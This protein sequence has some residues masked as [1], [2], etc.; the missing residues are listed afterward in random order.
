MS[1]AKKKRSNATATK[2][3]GSKKP[4]F[5]LFI[6]IVAFGAILILALQTLPKRRVATDTQTKKLH[7]NFN[8]FSTNPMSAVQASSTET[9]K[10]KSDATDVDEAVACLNRGTELL[11][12]GKIEAAIIEY[13]KAVKFNPEDE[14]THYNLAFA[15]AKQGNKAA[16]KQQYLE[17]LRI[18][19]DYAEAHNNLGN[20]LVNEGNFDEAIEHF[21]GA[22]RISPDNASANNNLGNALA[23]QGKVNEAVTYFNQALQ[24]K[25]DYLEARYNLGNAYLAQRRIDEA[26]NVFSEILRRKPDFEPA[27]RSLAKARQL[28]T[29]AGGN[30]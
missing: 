21:K 14:D 8:T 5:G 23:R 9:E 26:V 3:S 25:P 27:R 16:A 28:Q 7:T 19:P 11:A 29:T 12:R 6:V 15:L 13:T 24:L 17:A 22:L 20:L 30:Q 1:Q 18:F 10:G 2:S 4:F